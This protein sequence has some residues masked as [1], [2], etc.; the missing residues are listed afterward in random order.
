VTLEPGI[1][2]VRAIPR[3]AGTTSA[4]VSLLR[5]A[6]DQRRFSPASRQ[7]HE[8][9]AA[10]GYSQTQRQLMEP[11]SVVS[12]AAAKANV[13]RG[14]SLV[15]GAGPGTAYWRWVGFAQADVTVTDVNRR[16]EIARK[17]QGRPA[18]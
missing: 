1:R 7:H 13:N 17:E 12:G 8:D 16:L 18:L 9:F 11:L 3:P 15:T 5:D 14:P 10:C 6:P 2:T 4:N